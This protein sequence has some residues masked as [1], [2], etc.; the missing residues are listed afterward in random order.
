MRSGKHCLPSPHV[1]QHTPPRDM[2]HMRLRARTTLG[3]GLS[4]RPNAGHRNAEERTA[5]K[6]AAAP[7]G[8]GG[9]ANSARVEALAHAISVTAQLL[10]YSR[11]LCDTYT[12]WC[13]CWGVVCPCAVSCLVRFGAEAVAVGDITPLAPETSPVMSPIPR[14]GRT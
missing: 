9:W 5:L 2:Q 11:C 12:C 13:V 3:P 7:F 6:A 4:Q 8:G 1:A 14:H 10:Q